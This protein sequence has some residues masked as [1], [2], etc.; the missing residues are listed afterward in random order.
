MPSALTVALSASTPDGSPT[1]RRTAKRLAVNDTGGYSLRPCGAFS[2][3]TPWPVLVAATF[4]GF[5]AAGIAGAVTATL[6][7]FVALWAL[8]MAAAQRAARLEDWPA[9]RA[10][11]PAPCRRS[12]VYSASPSWR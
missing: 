7:A 4:I 8:A 2:Y 10:S 3:L 6:G 5:G 9:L 11:E 12:S 1:S